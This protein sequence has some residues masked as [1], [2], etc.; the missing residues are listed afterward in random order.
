MPYIQR[1]LVAHTGAGPF[2][3]RICGKCYSQSSSL[4]V[5]IKNVHMI[6]VHDYFDCVTSNEIP[7]HFCK[8]CSYSSNKLSY[9]RHHEVTHTVSYGE[10]I[11]TDMFKCTSTIEGRKYICKICCYSSGNIGHMRDHQR[12]HTGEHPFQ[13]PICGRKF[14]QKS[15]LNAHIRRFHLFNLYSDFDL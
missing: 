15:S 1:H 2:C 12:K 6:L 3:S 7:K 9:I 13:C 8:Y 5:L 4:D 11:K 10:S 14:T